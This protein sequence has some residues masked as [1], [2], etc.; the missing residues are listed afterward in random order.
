MKKYKVT[1]R[2][3]WFL[4]YSIEIEC[5]RIVFDHYV[6]FYKS[7]NQPPIFSLNKNNFISCVIC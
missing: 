7:D 6:L 4:I 5:C 3:F 2:V 1:Y